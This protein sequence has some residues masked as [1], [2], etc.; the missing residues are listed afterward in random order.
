ML[1]R[2]VLALATL[3]APV[4]AL[5]DGGAGGSG[6]V[7]SSTHAAGGEANYA[8]GGEGGAGANGSVDSGAG[9][10][11]AGFVAGAGGMTPYGGLGGTGGVHGR[12]LSV[13]SGGISGSFVGSPGG[14]GWQATIPGGGGGGGGEG[15]SGLVIT[16][17]VTS[18]IGPGSMI[19]YGSANGGSGGG[20]GT[21]GLDGSGLSSG[22]WGGDGGNGVVVTTSSGVSLASSITSFSGGGGGKGGSGNTDN[23]GLAGDGGRGGV[24]LLYITTASSGSV[25]E[26]SLVDGGTVRGGVG[27]G[28][29]FAL[30]SPGGNGGTGGNGIQ[31][32]AGAYSIDIGGAGQV[33]G[34]RGGVGGFSAISTPGTGGSGGIGI[35]GDNIA[36]NNHGSISGGAGGSNTNPGGGV[37]LGGV[38][39]QG[40]DLSIETDGLIAGGV[41]GDLATQAPAIVFTGGSNVLRFDGPVA[42]LTG[43]I[44][45]GA[46]PSPGLTALTFNQ[47]TDIVLPNDITG[48]GNITKKGVGTLAL[49]GNNTFDGDVDIAQGTLAVG[50]DAALG[51]ASNKLAFGDGAALKWLNAFDLAPTRGITLSPGT[52]TLDTNGFD[53]TISTRIAGSGSLNKAGDGKLTLLLNQAYTGTTTI[54]GGTLQLGDGATGAWLSGPIVD[55]GQLVL[56]P[57]AVG[58]SL[59]SVVQGSGSVVVG[60][61]GTTLLTADSTY[62]G[63]TTVLPGAIL[64]LGRRDSPNDTGSITGDL[65]N[66]GTVFFFRNG[67]YAYN[68]AISGNGIV[69]PGGAG[70]LALNGVSAT[71]GYMEVMSGKLLV[72][73]NPV[74]HGNA[75][76]GNSITVDAGATLGGYGS[77]GGAVRLNA[78]AHLQPGNGLG[79]LTVGSLQGLP[80]SFLDVSLGAPGPN[81]TIPGASG[82]VAV[83]GDLELDG[84][85]V[86]VAYASGMGAGVYNLFSYGGTLTGSMP[87]LNKTPIGSSLFV[88]GLSDDKRINLV[89]GDVPDLN[90][91]NA[92]GRALPSRMGGGSGTWSRTATDWADMAGHVM[93][94]MRPQPGFAIFGGT[95]GTVNVSNAAGAV[96]ATG[97][98]FASDGYAMTGDAL[99][100]VAD[101]GHPAPVQVTVGDGS[102]ASAGWTA[103]LG[104]VLAGSDGLDKRGLGTLVLTGMNTYTGGTTISAGKLSIGDDRSLGDI[105]NALT[106]N[107]GVLRVT[108]ATF[109]GTLR[110]ITLGAAGGGF[111]IADAVNTFTLNQALS[112]TGS[113]SKSG[114]GTLV[115]VRDNSYGGGTSVTAGTLQLGI[116]GNFGGIAGD[117]NVGPAG[118]LAFDRGDI[119][120]FGGA[121]SGAGTVRQ[122]GVGT[123]VLAGQNTFTGTTVI[124][125]GQ[126]QVGDGATSGSLSG[127][128]RNNSRLVF[129]RSDD[130]R[131]GGSISGAGTLTKLGAGTLAL[132]G[133]SSGYAGMTQVAMGG[134]QVDGA[135]GGT[136]FVNPMTTL[137]G[138]GAVGPATIAF[139]A[140]L[141]P[142]NAATPMGT[143]RVNGDL[144]F[145]P[146][147]T[148][149]VQT[150]ADGSHGSVHVAGTASLAGSVV[151]LGQDGTYAASTSYTILTA[152]NGVRGAFGAVSSNLAYLTPSLAYRANDVDLLMQLKQVPDEGGSD[153]GGGSDSGGGSDDG[154]GTRPIRFADLAATHNQRAVANALQSLPASNGLYTRVLNLPEGA[155]PAVFDSMSGEAYAG[156]IAV[157]RG[158]SDNVT[159]VPLSHFRANLDAARLPGAATAQLGNG[160]ASALPSSAAQPVWAQVFGNWRTLSGNGDA[161]RTQDSDGGLFLG[162]DHGVGNGWRVGG[163]LGYTDS[164]ATVR[165]L[166]STTDA[167]SYS[168]TIYG[169]K[170]F[171][172][173]PGKINVTV[174]AAYTWHDVKTRRSVDA[175]G[176]N[177]SLKS[178]YHASTGQ[179]FTELG[180]ALPLNDRVSVEPFVGADYSDLRTRG[181]AESGGDAALAGKP[182]RSQLATTTLGLHAQTTFESAGAQG[183]LHATVGWRH[184]YGDVDPKATLAFDGSQP[185]TVYGA[186]VAHDSAVLALGVD[187]EVSRHTT[188]GVSYNGQFGAG[189]QLNAGMLDV[190]YRF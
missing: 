49:T 65:V 69:V 184:A 31:T 174:G 57:P 61:G 185:F 162:G 128:I 117:V 60:G 104:N 4:A 140:T 9:G 34:G 190:K 187:M 166:S 179:F 13:V 25:I 186:P 133:D 6:V 16:S 90:F 28:G 119:V 51:V 84:V 156:T 64:Q 40:S 161:Y 188:V 129:N 176:A 71:P 87:I 56:D 88:Q 98:Q 170:G 115:L 45:L 80:G 132:S 134:L 23:A 164:H 137:S 77:V 62:T 93:G 97:M 86:N 175:A 141:S 118:T 15:G 21:A 11:G 121:I 109:R 79:T 122:M 74:T 75:V 130:T 163:A 111:D 47:P 92:D 167:D 116:G 108:G 189:S 43:D 94:A 99:T 178:N 42:G 158:V 30:P 181:F 183:R 151:D 24:G 101:G 147:A 14:D 32:G 168:A 81:W 50:S 58:L 157:L 100:L 149:R 135:L 72:G 114:D 131:F 169:G 106:L 125:A 33:V 78:G 18:P 37:S 82:S 153:N 67:D 63:S 83:T 38:A 55:N 182:G 26:I 1:R 107:G 155:P 145:M 103:T 17:P 85:R 152:D 139:G 146:G 70:T 113:L 95:A 36:V 150:A 126:L 159:S 173:G 20:G 27:G 52:A 46:S 53:T 171:E 165:D 66:N 22:G 105:A 39:I 68:G 110:D 154:G 19:V 7:A 112:G 123:L 29:G 138:V 172:A 91:W 142:G 136:L 73:D 3:F 8:P 2:N 48:A 102:A 143:L 54:S 160:D 10:G 177:E 44:Q 127:D 89:S 120:T 124:D 144:T 148:L 59:D 12:E 35:L 5:A 96:Q 180:Y 76:Y 41:S